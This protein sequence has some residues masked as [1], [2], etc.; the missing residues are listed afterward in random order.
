MPQKLKMKLDD[1]IQAMQNQNDVLE[2]F[3][4]MKTCEI[5]VDEDMEDIASEDSAED[6]FRYYYIDPIYEGDTVMMM[7]DFADSLADG[8]AKKAAVEAIAGC[9]PVRTFYEKIMANPDWY[10][11]WKKFEDGQLKE[12]AGEWLASNDLELA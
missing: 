11:Q 9:N 12:I 6:E 10:S 1:L 4:D 3:L 5:I 7:E 8:P 2:L